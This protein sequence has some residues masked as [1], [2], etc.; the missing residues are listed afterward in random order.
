MSMVRQHPVRPV[1]SPAQKQ[2]LDRDTMTAAY[3]RLFEDLVHGKVGRA[4]A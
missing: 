2:A 4:A 1:L 3:L